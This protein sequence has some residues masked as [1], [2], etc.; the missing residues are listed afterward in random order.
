MRTREE[1]K[2]NRSPSNNDF[3]RYDWRFK[4]FSIACYLL[5]NGNVLGKNAIVVEYCNLRI[6][7]GQRLF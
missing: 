3:L 6:A 4:S 7:H 5:R 1:E 2:K